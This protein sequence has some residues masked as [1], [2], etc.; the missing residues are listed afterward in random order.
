MIDLPIFLSKEKGRFSE[1]FFPSAFLGLVK[2]SFVLPPISVYFLYSP[3]LNKV[4]GVRAVLF[5]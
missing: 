4:P 1:Y 2:K 3:F 5:F